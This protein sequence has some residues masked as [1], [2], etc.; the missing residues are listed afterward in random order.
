M[1]KITIKLVVNLQVL[2]GTLVGAV[3][4]CARN[5]GNAE[6]RCEGREGCTARVVRQDA[7]RSWIGEV[8]VA[9]Y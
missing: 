2:R 3:D 6:A 8:A 9:R 1:F 4:H 7:G 5:A